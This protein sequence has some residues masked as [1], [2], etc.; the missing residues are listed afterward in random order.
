MYYSVCKQ[1]SRPE[2]VPGAL[3]AIERLMRKGPVDEEALLKDLLWGSDFG[4]QEP[5]LEDFVQYWQ[6]LFDLRAGHDVW[7]ERHWARV[8]AEG[9]YGLKIKYA[10]AVALLRGRGDPEAVA[11]MLKGISNADTAGWRAREVKNEARLALA[12][13]YFEQKKYPEA[14]EAY[15]SVEL[16]ELD[17]GR[18]SIYLEEA[19]ALYRSNDLGL[20][21]GRLAALDSPAFRR[22]YLPE[23]YQLRGLI[24][25]DLCRWLPA[26]R[27]ARDFQRHHA[28]TLEAVRQRESYIEVEQVMAAAY[29]E[30]AL[31]RL[32]TRKDQ[33]SQEEARLVKYSGGFTA[34]GLMKR[35]TRA[36]DLARAEAD[37]ALAAESERASARVVDSMLFM[38]E[39]M[40]IL[41]YEIGLALYQRA[42][43]GESVAVKLDATYEEKDGDVY[44]A[45]DKEF[46]ND[47]LKDMRF[48]LSSRC[49]AQGVGR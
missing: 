32:A 36:Y 16:P 49:A 15:R 23:K 1:R 9:A 3:A 39:Q 13:L 5:P 48:S 27:A 12:R 11:A 18:G 35:L 30:G 37:R 46:W 31:S 28:K 7:S 40:R 19:W 44:Y 24:Y 8:R 21:M 22:L 25:K 10:R 4:P 6:G 47:E 41:D 14:V 38:D 20:A 2:V 26:K 34:S 17:P 33:L 29:Q 42:R 45:F 43:K